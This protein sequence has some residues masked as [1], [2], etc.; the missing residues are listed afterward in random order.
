MNQPR[1]LWLFIFFF[2]AMAMQAQTNLGKTT[3]N[4]Q[5]VT[6]MLDEN[7]DT[8]LIADDL[9][10]VSLT[11]PRKFKSRKDY[12]RYR[13]YLKCAAIVYPYAKEAIAVFRQ[14]KVETEEMRR[15]KR[16]RYAKKLQKQ[17]D[18]KFEEPLKNL[19]KI[20]GK[21]LVKMVEKELDTPLYT[22][23]KTYRGGLTAGYWN[24]LSKFWGYD[25]KRGYME[26]DD[27]ILDAVLQDFPLTLPE[28]ER[29]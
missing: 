13:Y 16:K 12:A 11:S 6:M 27:P 24:T 17:L 15:G 21:I 7:G 10:T 1:F 26:G 22:L 18:D 20:Q 29:Y 8:L 2:V 9:M 4:G 14:L 5:L 28:E 23:I 25:L 3:I 19:T